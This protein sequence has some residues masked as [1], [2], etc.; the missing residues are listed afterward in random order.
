[1]KLDVIEKIGNKFLTPPSYN[2]I[3]N[4]IK[5]IGRK[6]EFIMDYPML[7][8]QIEYR[9]GGYSFENKEEPWRIIAYGFHRADKIMLIPDGCD[10]LIMSWG[11]TRPFCVRPDKTVRTELEFPPDCIGLCGIRA[12]PGCAINIAGNEIE[13][14]QAQLISARTPSEAR[15]M[16]LRGALPFI[17]KRRVSPVWERMAETVCET[18]GR[19]T[20]A[21]LAQR[22]GYTVRH[23]NNLFRECAG[24]APK[25]FCRFVRF[26]NALLEMTVNPDGENSDFIERLSYA[27]Q[28]HFQREFREFAGMTPKQFIKLYLLP[29][30]LEKV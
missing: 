15:D 6:G 27:D 30:Y 16:V 9:K 3:L 2:N 25:T 26:Q 29:M 11:T 22:F 17:E 14:I 24:C 5:R 8:P 19:C 10:E 21:M 12:E 18:R 13:N 7:Q 20:V 4:N 28:A 23:V 1:M